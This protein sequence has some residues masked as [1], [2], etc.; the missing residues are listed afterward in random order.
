MLAR[1]AEERANLFFGVCPRPRKGCERAWHIRT[2]PAL[3]ADID[4]CTPDEAVQRCEKAGLPRPSIIV[5]SGHGV[6]LYWL[7]VEPYVIDDAGLP[8]P[9]GQYWVPARRADGSTI[10]KADG[11]PKKYPRNYVAGKPADGE[12]EYIW[13]YLT[14]PITGGDSKRKNPLFPSKLS[15][16]RSTHRIFSRG[17]PR[18][19]AATPPT[20]SH[21]YYACR[22]R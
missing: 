16:K 8:R 13:E 21:A 9:I 22:G 1:A 14:D 2:V 3:W 20:T 11:E 10:L 5:N 4:H 19:S 6:H 17:L 12:D 15:A 18:N 7:L